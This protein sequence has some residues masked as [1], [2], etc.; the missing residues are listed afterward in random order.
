MRRPRG[1]RFAR[2]LLGYHGGLGAQGDDR[3]RRALAL[4]AERRPVARPGRARV[5]EGLLDPPPPLAL[6]GQRRRERSALGVGLGEPG[7]QGDD[8][9]ARLLR[10][11]G[12]GERRRRARARRRRGR[13]RRPHRRWRAPLPARA[14]APPAPG[15]PSSRSASSASRAL[16]RLASAATWAPSGLARLACRASISS[17]ARRSGR[18]ARRRAPLA[19]ERLLLARASSSASAWREAT[20]LARALELGDGRV[21]ARRSASSVRTRNCVAP[22]IDLRLGRRGDRVVALPL[23]LADQLQRRALVVGHLRQRPLVVGEQAGPLLALLGQGPFE[24]GAHLGAA[25]RLAQ[26]GLHRRRAPPGRR[27]APPRGRRGA[28]PAR[29]RAAPARPA[30]EPLLGGGAGGRRAPGRVPSWKCRRSRTA[31]SGHLSPRGSRGPRL[32][33]PCQPPR[34]IPPPTWARTR[35]RGYAASRGWVARDRSFQ[36]PGR[37]RTSVPADSQA[38]VVPNL[39]P[40]G[41]YMPEHSLGHCL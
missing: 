8:L 11:L 39:L 6:V 14:R 30:R 10:G 24:L 5:V 33:G 31:L 15:V 21:A 26:L 32:H 28:P 36:A 1:V 37:H 18:P 4:V 3:R 16:R 20:S 23:A 25:L 19:G 38:T 41:P 35:V 27:P 2:A 34:P 12:Q 7:A 13:R 9:A 29:A 22:R 40:F 17:A